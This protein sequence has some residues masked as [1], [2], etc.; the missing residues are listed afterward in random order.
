MATFGSMGQD[1]ERQIAVLQAQ[2]RQRLADLR[3]IRPG[4]ENYTMAADAVIKAA[5]ELIDYEERLPVLLDLPPRRLSLLIVRWSGMVPAAVGLSLSVAALA[6]WLPRWWL[7]MVAVLFGAAA[8]LLRMPVPGPCDRHAS[9]RPG[10]VL[11][12]AGGLV[13][14]IAA[15][16]RLPL[17]V[18]GF[19]L[20]FLAV[21][22]W[23]VRGQIV[24]T[25]I[26]ARTQ[27]RS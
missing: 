17:W 5:A 11:V 8:Q 16:V 21:G 26:G 6:G 15:A 20:V 7:L 23:Q 24:G 12:G 3:P 2:V 18:A 14:G 19:G 4:S 10:A 1:P 25:A 27:G 13:I 22:L 9:L